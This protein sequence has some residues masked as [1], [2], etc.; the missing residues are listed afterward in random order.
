MPPI[1]PPLR[2]LPPPPLPFPSPPPAELKVCIC[3]ITS[4]LLLHIEE[5]W[6][7]GRGSVTKMSCLSA[8]SVVDKWWRPN[9]GHA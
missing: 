3:T 7:L 1:M 4:K 6:R 2:D 9:Q 5:V 8:A